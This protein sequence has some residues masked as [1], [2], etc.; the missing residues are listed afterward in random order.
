M[1][2][3]TSWSTVSPGH[4]VS[5]LVLRAQIGIPGAASPEEIGFLESI[6]CPELGAIGVTLCV[7]LA[8]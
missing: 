4:F 8:L 2:E 7:P 3:I 5:F 6:H 1:R